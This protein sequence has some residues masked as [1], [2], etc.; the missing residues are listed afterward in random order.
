MHPPVPQKKNKK[1][2]IK[3]IGFEHWHGSNK[4]IKEGWKGANML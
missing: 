3:I 1:K 2:E 4:I